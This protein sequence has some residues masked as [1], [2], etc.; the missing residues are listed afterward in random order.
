IPWLQCLLSAVGAGAVSQAVGVT[1]IGIV[2]ALPDEARSLGVAR[3]RSGRRY[4]LNANAVLRVGGMGHVNAT[5]AAQA[6]WLD[7]VNALARRGFCGALDAT[8]PA[9]ALTLPATTVDASAHIVFRIDT[10][11]H[12]RLQDS[13][14]ADTR[15][16]V[17]T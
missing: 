15:L 11:R 9:G 10:D 3:P 2:T 6:R 1:Q 14:T 13:L 5:R 17:T 12:T 7:N 8:L 16:S 4:A